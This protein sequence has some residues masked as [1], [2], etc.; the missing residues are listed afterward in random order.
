MSQAITWFPQP[1]P[2]VILTTR[3]IRHYEDP[4]TDRS[5]QITLSNIAYLHAVYNH[6]NATPIMH[7]IIA[8]TTNT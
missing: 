8:T 5:R 3:F 7:T 1:T 2:T 6:V 4:T